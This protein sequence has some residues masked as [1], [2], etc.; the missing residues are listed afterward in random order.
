MAMVTLTLPDGTIYTEDVDILIFTV[1]MVKELFSDI[2]GIETTKFILIL[3]GTELVGS[4]PLVAYGVTEG[5]KLIL[6]VKADTTC[7]TIG[8]QNMDVCVP[9]TIKPFATAGEV[10]TNCCGNATITPGTGGCKGKDVSCGFTITQTLC[11]AV[12]I[13]FGAETEVGATNIVCGDATSEPCKDCQTA[14][15]ELIQLQG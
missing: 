5:D 3:N 15:D 9:V 14:S 4:D 7:S 1:D 12:P 2:T 13:S 6:T 10:I 8:Y 11:V